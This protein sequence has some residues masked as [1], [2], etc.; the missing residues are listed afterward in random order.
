MAERPYT[1]LGQRIQALREA[2]GWPPSALARR[3]D[4][5]VDTIYSI[6]Q[7]RVRPGL[8]LL[9]RLATVLDAD[10]DELARLAGH[11]QAE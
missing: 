11:T 6:E 7:G 3:A 5:S 8:D 4:I 9:T 10:Y 1:A 2:R